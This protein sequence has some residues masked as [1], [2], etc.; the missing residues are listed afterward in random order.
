MTASENRFTLFGVMLH[1]N[2]Y[3]RRSLRTRFVREPD[4]N[5]QIVIAMLG[6]LRLRNAYALG[7][8]DDWNAPLTPST[9]G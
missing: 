9:E 8:P 6:I 4:V 2:S 7:L 5:F 3:Q 1:A